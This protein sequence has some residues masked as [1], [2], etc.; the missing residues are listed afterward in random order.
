MPDM[1]GYYV[2]RNNYIAMLMGAQTDWW[3]VREFGRDFACAGG[4]L[5][6]A[7]VLGSGNF[8]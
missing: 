5:E 1:P 6:L 7:S 3:P 4:L 8:R 2:R